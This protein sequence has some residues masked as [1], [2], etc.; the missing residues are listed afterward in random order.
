FD[1][2]AQGHVPGEGGAI[3]VIE[4][5]GAARARGARVYGE[6]AGYGATFDAAAR[7]R[8]SAPDA[9]RVRSPQLPFLPRPERVSVPGGE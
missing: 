8:P 7:S 1:T 5:A 6:I 4:E 9:L 2:R 3:L